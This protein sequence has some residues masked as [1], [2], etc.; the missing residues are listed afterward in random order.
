[1]QTVSFPRLNFIS[2]YRTLLSFKN[3]TPFMCSNLLVRHYSLSCLCLYRL[4]LRKNKYACLSKEPIC[5]VFNA[6]SKRRFLHRKKSSTSCPDGATA[7]KGGFYTY[8]R[9]NFG[10][11]LHPCIYTYYPNFNA[12]V[13][14]FRSKERFLH[15]KKRRFLSTVPFTR[16][17]CRVVP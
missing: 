11:T 12:S 15:R 3:L 6:I 14:P 4:A 2:V 5:S 9:E 8:G 7:V 17:G 13:S 10:F 16:S 1:M